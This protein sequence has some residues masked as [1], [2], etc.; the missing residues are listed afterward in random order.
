M[1]HSDNL[2]A[3]EKIHL[4]AR[5]QEKVRPCS[6]NAIQAVFIFQFKA[7]KPA[8]EGETQETFDKGLIK[9]TKNNRADRKRVQFAEKI[10]SLLPSLN[11]VCSVHIKFQ[12]LIKKGAKIFI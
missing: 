1:R 8:D 9:T 7:G 12:L 11:N 5:D 6:N 10:N 4:Q 3:T 2:R